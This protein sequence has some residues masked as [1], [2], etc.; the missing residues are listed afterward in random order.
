MRVGADMHRAAM[1]AMSINT[2][3]VSL[4]PS[5]ADICNIAEL[6]VNARH[7]IA[8]GDTM[9]LPPPNMDGTPPSQQ[10]QRPQQHAAAPPMLHPNIYGTLP[11]VVNS[12]LQPA[13]GRG[14]KK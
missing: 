4:Y 1:Q 3:G 10:Q 11:T 8:P 9:P 12:L 5:N 13:R 2:S 14:S 6:V 7:G